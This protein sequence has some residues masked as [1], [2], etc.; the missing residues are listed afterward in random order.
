MIRSAANDFEL[1]I[2]QVSKL[3]ESLPDWKKQIFKAEI[4][5][6]KDDEE[7]IRKLTLRQP[8]FFL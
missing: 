4:K 5:R 8:S 1:L 7:I 2:E 3:I 6:F